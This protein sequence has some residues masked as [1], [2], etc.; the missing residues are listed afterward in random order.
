MG[1]VSV[2]ENVTLNGFFAGPDGDLSW[3]YANNS[4]AE[5]QE[6]TQRNAST[7]GVLLLGRVTYQMMESFWPTPAAAKIDPVVARGMNEAE[8]IVFSRSLKSV[9]WANTTL[10]PGDI[11]GAVRRL[12]QE[13]GKDLVVL[14]S[15]SIVTQLT[16]AGLVDEYQI[17][18]K[19]VVL[20]QGRPLF[21]GVD[22]PLALMLTSSR[23]FGNGTII[24]NYVPKALAP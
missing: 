5:L 6:F 16:N 20:G 13:S 24:L 19:P 7:P 11:P 3:A 1:K 22:T 9:T 4:D 12:K 10:V 21:E 18:V 23:S 2:F 17:V 14:G 15:G 8:K